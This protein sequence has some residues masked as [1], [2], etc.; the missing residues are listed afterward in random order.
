MTVK[1]CCAVQN[2]TVEARAM[3][4]S[5]GVLTVLTSVNYTCCIAFIDVFTAFVVNQRVTV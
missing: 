4:A 1:Q 3:K 5:W 2:I